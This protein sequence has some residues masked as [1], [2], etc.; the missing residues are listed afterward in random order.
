[1][2]LIY[3]SYFFKCDKD[4]DGFITVQELYELIESRE[5]EQD[6]PDYVVERIHQMHD[7]N[8]DKRLSY[9]EFYEMINNPALQYIFGHYLNRLFITI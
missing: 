9:E 4:K 1:M 5:Y 7:R 2:F 8:K 3:N 6:I